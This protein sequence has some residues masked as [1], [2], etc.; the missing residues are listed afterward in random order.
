VPVTRGPDYNQGVTWN[1]SKDGL[2][3]QVAQA[4][5]GSGTSGTS[6]VPFFPPMAG[7]GIGM[8][9]QQQGNQERERTTWLAEDG[10]IWGNAPI[11]GPASTGRD[12]AEPATAS[13]R[14]QSRRGT[15]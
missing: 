1:T 12:F 3:A 4:P 11:V 13:R 9:G 5:G 14:A 7:A 10:N 2:K 15:H 6:A 8:G